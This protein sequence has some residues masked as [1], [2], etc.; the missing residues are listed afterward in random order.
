[1]KKILGLSKKSRVKPFGL[2][3]TAF[4]LPLFMH[5]VDVKFFQKKRLHLVSKTFETSKEKKCVVEKKK[6]I[7]MSQKLFCWFNQNC[8]FALGTLLEKFLVEKKTIFS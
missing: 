7:P 8:F 6:Q 1:L 5:I 3:K 2:K 4:S